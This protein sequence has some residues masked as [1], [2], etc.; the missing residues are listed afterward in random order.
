MRDPAYIQNP[1]SIST[2]SFDPWPVTRAQLITVIGLLSE[3]LQL[4]EISLLM[5]ALLM[6]LLLSWKLFKLSY[7]PE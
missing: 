5:K 7:V 2:I 3:V 4:S 6:R 1:S